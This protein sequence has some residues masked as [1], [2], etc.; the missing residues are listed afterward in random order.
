MA[1]VPALPSGGVAGWKILT[2][3]Y[4]RQLQSFSKS[5]QVRSDRDYLVGK[6]SEPISVEAFLKDTRLVRT[7]MM[8]FDLTGEEWKKGLIRKVLTEAADPQ[9]NFL[10][11][12]SN[13]KYS[14]MASMLSPN[15]DGMIVLDPEKAAALGVRF[16]SNAF[17]VAVGNVDDAMR[18]ALNF[19]SEISELAKEGSSD[20]TIAFRLMSDIPMFTVLKTTL[21]LP[22]SVSKL[23]VDRQAALIENNLKKALG[24]SKLSE[25]SDPPVTE[26]LIV[27]FHAMKSMSDTA[28]AATPASAALTLLSGSGFGFGAGAVENLFRSGS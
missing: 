22:T 14:A 18:L 17:E 26:K 11:R 19:R 23:P 24:I 5:P 20:R 27:R 16:E 3:T 25:L 13:P 8:A 7:A 2:A 10:D 6:M 1:F 4:D 15:P 12:L 21:N 28:S 9:S